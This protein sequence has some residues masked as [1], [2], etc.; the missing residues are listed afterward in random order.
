MS[1]N[2][3]SGDISKIAQNFAASS[4]RNVA[5]YDP[6]IVA[7][8]VGALLKDA[9]ASAQAAIKNISHIAEAAND[10]TFGGGSAHITGASKS[11]LNGLA[12]LFAKATTKGL[13]R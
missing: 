11:G 7:Q 9:Q 5:K 10:F 12:D 1:L 3:F 2:P 8:E 6:E 13:S 4:L